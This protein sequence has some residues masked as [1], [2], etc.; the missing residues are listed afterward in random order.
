MFIKSI[1]EV[2]DACGFA[3]DIDWDIPSTQIHSRSTV[4]FSCT[5]DHEEKCEELRPTPGALASAFG[6]EWAVAH[7]ETIAAGEAERQEFVFPAKASYMKHVTIT[8]KDED[9]LT[10]HFKWQ[11]N[12]ASGEKVHCVDEE[13]KA[14]QD[15]S[16]EDGNKAIVQPGDI[17]DVSQFSGSKATYG[18]VTSCPD[19]EGECRV[20]KVASDENDTEMFIYESRNVD[21]K[22]VVRAIMTRNVI[23]PENDMV[24][25]FHQLEETTVAAY[26]AAVAVPTDCASKKAPWGKER[27]TYRMRTVTPFHDDQAYDK[28]EKSLV[29][30]DA[31][32]RKVL[33]AHSEHE[34]FARVGL[35]ESEAEALMKQWPNATYVHT[36]P[37]G[38]TASSSAELSLAIGR[39][40]RSGRGWTRPPTRLPLRT[41]PPTSTRTARSTPAARP[42]SLLSFS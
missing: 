38:E 33:N 30:A 32:D 42:S 23:M 36:T 25:I 35:V 4:Y 5:G 15:T 24:Q 22:S 40:P 41:P 1:T 11:E 8:N 29:A 39:A 21:G 19:G 18:G 7:R 9:G 12:L 10:T 20:F 37:S 17:V 31:T 28:Y 3:A 34:A 13:E 26:T 16:V 2:S 27:G 14:N 6:Q